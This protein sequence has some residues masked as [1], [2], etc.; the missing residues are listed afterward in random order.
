MNGFKRI[1]AVVLGS[2]FFIAGVLKLMDPLGSQLVVEEY[3]K[4]FHLGF[5][6]FAASTLGVM[7]ALVESLLGA[8]LITGVWRKITALCTLAVLGVFT[9]VTAVLW[10]ANPQMDCGCFG[11]ALHLEHWQSFV[12]NLVLIGLWAV[13]FLPISKL[14]APQKIKYASF[15]IGV[16]SVVLFGLFSLL[17]IPLVDFASFKPGTELVGA[18]E[19]AFAEVTAAVYSKNGQEGVFTPDCPPDSTWTFVRYQNYDRTILKNDAPGELLSFCDASGIY[20]D[21]LATQG[22][23]LVLSSYAPEKLGAKRISSISR[24]ASEA[25]EAGY[26]VLFLVAGTPETVQINEPSLAASTYFAD[27][28]TLMTL[29]RSNGGAVYISDGLVISKWSVRALPSK[30]DLG[31]LVKKDPVEYMMSRSGK[32]KI[33]LQG[34]LL[35]TF[36]V[37]LLL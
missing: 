7:L 20:A 24:V 34:V 28:K 10:V 15:G 3:L 18:N 29:N 26:S 31:K 8:A 25:A 14:N 16:V 4:F 12:K 30:E 19:E 6:G 5:L 36:A 32:G 11:E 35:Y 37:M 27:R 9:L 1:C 23:V 2:V 22:P 13:A 33:R 21:S 17:S